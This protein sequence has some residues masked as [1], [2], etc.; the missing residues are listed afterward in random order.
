MKRCGDCYYYEPVRGACL[1]GK[2][3]THSMRAACKFWVS[4]AAKIGRIHV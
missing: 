2:I 3:A 1:R 4:F